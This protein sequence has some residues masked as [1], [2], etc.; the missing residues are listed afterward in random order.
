MILSHELKDGKKNQEVGRC[1]FTN[2]V[3]LCVG[4]SQDGGIMP[5]KP[6]SRTEG[7]RQKL[8]E[9]ND[10][11]GLPDLESACVLPHEG[12][13]GHSHEHNLVGIVVLFLSPFISLPLIRYSFSTRTT[14]M[15]THMR[16][17]GAVLH[18]RCYPQVS[19]GEG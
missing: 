15:G 16:E 18:H 8:L 10:L 13:H 6:K 9:E 7:A 11:H 19:R 3:K 4:L 14:R 2:S 1:R 12:T 5:K 17:M